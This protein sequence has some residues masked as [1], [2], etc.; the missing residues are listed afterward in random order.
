MAVDGGNLEIHD[1][2]FQSNSAFL[3]SVSEAV[4]RMS[5]MFLLQFP[6][7]IQLLGWSYYGR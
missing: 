7:D 4:I 2:I 3:V 1:T 6:T 5:L